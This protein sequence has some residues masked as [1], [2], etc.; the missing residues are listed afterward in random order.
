MKMLDSLSI[1]SR[2]LLMVG[3][4]AG[5]GL[6][7]LLTA[8]ISFSGFRGDVR[9]VSGDVADAT[10]ALTLVS[11]VQSSLQAQQRGLNNMLLRN[12]MAAEFDK[13]R[14]EFLA[15]RSAFWQQLEALEAIQKTSPL[16]AGEKVGDIRKLAGE[17][18]QLYDQVLAENE[19][20]MP[21]YTVMVDAALRD[22]DTP[23]VTALAE[24]FAAISEATTQTVGEAAVVADRRFE[25]N[26]LLVLV[27]GIAGALIS[28]S[29]AAYLSRH[30]LRRL[31]GELEPVVLATSRVAAGDLTQSLHTGK[32]AANSL[33][34]SIERMQSRLR[35]LIGDVKL[36]AEQTSSNALALRH[37]ALEV[38]NATGLQSDAAAMIT[39]AIEELTTAIS[40]MAESAGSAADAAK[41][42]R[43]TANESSRVIHQTISEIAAISDQAN[44]SSN[45]MLDLKTHTLEISRFAQEIKEIS[46]QTNLLSLNAAIEAARAG[47]AGRGF[48]VVADEVRKLANHTSETTHKIENL[49]TKL[50]EAADQ[51]TQVVAATAAR[52]QRGTKLA[53]EAELATQKIEQFCERSAIAA[54][55]IV[56]VLGEQR[57]A[58]EQIAQ[59]TERMAQMI[60]RGAKAA[61]ESSASAHEVATLADRLR[62]STLQFSV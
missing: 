18:N 48:A 57:L 34:V 26:V 32:A 42:T 2:L 45:S 53:S 52:A 58:A 59:N 51:T 8:L 29:L 31:G 13:G 61:A 41:V 4:S 35:T 3:V 17:L 21:K 47:E 12:F 56:D 7:L 33:V 16:K 50:S 24:T 10:K 38:A 44:A 43:Q 49:V 36:G 23:L 55:E 54:S 62:A 27:V 19:P 30:I 60:E 1:R 46:E 37:S 40:V 20:G 15:G 11:G 5:F 25:E 14:A 39:A 9:Q 6:L 22:A 28:L